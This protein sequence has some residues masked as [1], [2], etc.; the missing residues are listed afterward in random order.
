MHRDLV[1]SAAQT[2]PQGRNTYLRS[3]SYDHSRCSCKL[4]RVTRNR[5]G[6]ERERERERIRHVGR[7]TIKS[8]D[9]A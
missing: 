4:E 9:V 3:L 8:F 2:Q 7:R 5:I 1:A 6:G